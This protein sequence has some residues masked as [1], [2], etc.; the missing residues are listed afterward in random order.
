MKRGTFIK[1]SL[2]FL[3]MGSVLSKF[4]FNPTGAYSAQ[5]NMYKKLFSNLENG[6]VLEKYADKFGEEY[7]AKI[8]NKFPLFFNNFDVNSRNSIKQLIEKH[9]DAACHTLQKMIREDF[10]NN[11]TIRLKGWILSETE[12]KL[13]ALYKMTI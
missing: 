2:T 3:T 9:G 12:A 11:N 5:K 7:M 10:K 4:P 13:S 1:A 8:E 6:F